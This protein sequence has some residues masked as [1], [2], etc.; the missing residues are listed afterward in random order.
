M[1]C[2]VSA[3]KPPGPLKVDSVGGAE[4]RLSD[5]PPTPPALFFPESWES[6]DDARGGAV[7]DRARRVPPPEDVAVAESPPTRALAEPP[8]VF[9]PGSK[10][11]PSLKK[12]KA[13]AEA[14]PRTAPAE[15]VVPSIN[16]TTPGGRHRAAD[17]SSPDGSS[18]SDARLSLLGRR[19]SRPPPP[20]P[21][22]R[23]VSPN[24]PPVAP[25]RTKDPPQAAKRKPTKAKGGPSSPDTAA[26]AA[27]GKSKSPRPPPPKKP[28]AAA[29][30]AGDSNSSLHLDRSKRLIR[31]IS[32]PDVLLKSGQ[33]PADGSPAV[34]EDGPP[35]D[36]ATPIAGVV[37]DLDV[38]LPE[39]E[40]SAMPVR[41]RPSLVRRTKAP[42]QDDIVFKILVNGEKRR[43]TFARS[44]PFIKLRAMLESQF[45]RIA[46]FA[47]YDEDGDEVALRNQAD[48]TEALRFYD[49]FE[50]NS[51]ELVVAL[52]TA[53]SDVSALSFD[54]PAG[55]AANARPGGTAAGS[56]LGKARAGSV[57][58]AA[59][60]PLGMVRQAHVRRS[61]L[62]TNM[63]STLG[64]GEG[65]ED[66]EN[67]ESTGPPIP[68]PAV[69]SDTR[70]TT[71][72][73]LD[74]LE[75][76]GERPVSAL[77]RH[78]APAADTAS[79]SG[80]QGTLELANVASVLPL[81]TPKTPM[82]NEMREALMRG[83]AHVQTS[84]LAHPS[85]AGESPVT[86]HLRRML[87]R[88]LTAAGMDEAEFGPSSRA[89][90]SRVE[91]G[92]AAP[93]DR[94]AGGRRARPNSAAQLLAVNRGGGGADGGMVDHGM[95]G[96]PR[97]VPGLDG[98]GDNL[99]LSHSSLASLASS[100]SSGSQAGGDAGG[101]AGD[102]APEPGTFERPL[103][104]AVG[105]FLGRGATARV[106]SALDLSTGKMIA[107]KQFDLTE[108][109]D[110]A[111]VDAVLE[112]V[113][114]LK[115]LKHPNI[116]RYL[117]SEHRPAS[118]SYFVLMELVAGGSLANLVSRFGRLEEDLLRNY[119]RQ[120]LLGLKYLHAHGVAHR[121]IKGANVLISKTGVIKLSDFGCSKR[122]SAQGTE[123]E[124]SMNRAGTAAFLSPEAIR[125]DGHGRKG[126][127]WALGCMM[128]ELS[129]GTLPWA[130]LNFSNPF[131]AMYQIAV[132][133]D[134]P[135]IPD[136]LSSD[137]R[138]FITACL[139]RDATLRP[140]C[141]ALLKHTFVRATAR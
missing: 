140:D 54:A 84:S 66:G 70:S 40:L 129:S 72:E 79:D 95:G 104:W 89:A 39:S 61:T 90:R 56:P 134:L 105:D 100:F 34:E 141:N 93:S 8:S 51:L 45:G 63:P 81:M 49:A 13:D 32:K 76:Y 69:D 67:A 5:G 55:P 112:E 1:G 133:N 128:I 38:G 99:D 19:P 28:G 122:L 37:S 114:L 22:S 87:A 3:K 15:A 83:L 10:G 25:V 96:T 64:R 4:Q 125:G 47:F 41:R 2:S 71:P 80:T 30:P 101:D 116:V 26:S 130:E 11:S 121:D 9:G 60:S 126:D 75:F 119:V 44:T 78:K 24:A 98:S 106:F 120:T 7:T 16:V 31:K 59:G 117:G 113:E 109:L 127:I 85:E 62:P 77:E 33:R 110:E 48:L 12:G 21:R 35:D 115:S 132:S 111:T 86:A 94:E 42:E 68:V 23:S 20:R 124:E 136:D 108:D 58:A 73:Y 82:T 74:R 52:G 14:R 27:T 6:R 103:R 123:N 135:A 18:Q 17:D 137:C 107:V 88:G 65:E 53:G 138:D 50:M 139:T 102:D 131:T 29:A 118:Q 57:V 91:V 97:P 46:T 92:G 43:R 36:A